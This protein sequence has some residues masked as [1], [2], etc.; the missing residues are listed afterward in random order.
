MRTRPDILIVDDSAIIVKRMV[1]RLAAIDGVGRISH[2]GS[3][4]AAREALDGWSPDIL[5]LDIQLGDGPSITLY[6]TMKERLEIPRVIV[7][8]NYPNETHRRKF[9]GAGADY[10]F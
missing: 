6:E 3:L 5:I 8:T 4:A 2:A 9:L 1:A 7:F 10:F